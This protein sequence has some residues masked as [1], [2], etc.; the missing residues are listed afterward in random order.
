MR[1]SGI[2]QRVEGLTSPID[3]PL[4]LG[5]CIIIISSAC[6]L[7]KKVHSAMAR[8]AAAAAPLDPARWRARSCM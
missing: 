8:R 6:A 4:G 5:G 7:S 1:G 2:G 3:R